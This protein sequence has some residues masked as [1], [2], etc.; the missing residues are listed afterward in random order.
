MGNLY[1]RLAKQISDIPLD[2]YVPRGA[3]TMRVMVGRRYAYWTERTRDQLRC[4][5]IDIH[6]VELC[7]RYNDESLFPIA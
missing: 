2:V 6:K 5:G 7:K 1:D 4:S 3:A